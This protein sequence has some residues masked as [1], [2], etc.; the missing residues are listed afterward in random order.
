MSQLGAIRYLVVLGCILLI[1]ACGG[2]GGGG[3]DT[4]SGSEQTESSDSGSSGTSE[5]DNSSEF[6]DSESGDGS[7][8]GNVD[9]GNEAGEN[10]STSDYVAPAVVSLWSD[11]VPFGEGRVIDD[12][13]AFSGTGEPGHI[14]E[15]WLNGVMN[16]STVVD[17]RGEWRIDFTV[18]TLIPDR[19]EVNLV[20]V[21]PAGESVA[22]ASTFTFRYDPTAPA[23]P[24]IS[25]I[26]DDSYVAGD[27]FTTDGTL[28]I[29]GTAEPSM[30]VTLYLNSVAIGTSIA[31]GEGNWSVD[32]SA[33]NLSDGSYMLTADS[34][35]LTL[36]SAISPQFPV[37]IDRVP[38]AAPSVLNISLDSGL[39]ATD[40]ITNDTRLVFD[41]VSEP[42]AQIRLRRDAT[43]LGNTTADASGNWSFDYSVVALSEGA[44]SVQLMATD[45]AGNQ[46]AWSSLFNL[47][48]DTAAPNPIGSIALQPDTGV[49]GDGVTATGAIQ[50]V[51][52]ADA[53]DYVEVFVDGSSVG[54]VL[55]DSSGDWILDLS[56]APLVNGNYS[57]TTQ[58]VDLAGNQSSVSPGFD[59]VINA[60]PPSMPVISG[61]TTDT[62]LASDG[63]TAD[64]TLEVLGTADAGADVYV[65]IDGVGVG[66]TTADMF[67]NWSF[68]HTATVLTDGVHILTAQAE[69]ISGLQS[70]M[71]V[72][73]NL[74]IDTAAPVVPAITSMTTDTGVLG[75]LITGDNTLLFSGTSEADATIEVFIGGS[76]VGTTTAN[77]SGV[78]TFD[79]SGT[80][81]S[82]GAYSITATAQDASGNTSVASSA[83]AIT[84]DTGLPAAPA[85]T[86][87]T[88]DTGVLG[89]LITGDNTL[90]FSGTSEA[91]ATIEIFIGASSVGTTTAN[92]SGVWTF[93]YSGTTLSDGAY[94]I[95][96]TAQDASGNTS[97]ASSAYAITIDTGLPA[98]P[99]ITAMTTD[100]G[101]LGDLI[102]GDNTLLF[103]GTS[104]A[105]ATIEIFIGAS[106]VGTTTANGS[107]VWTFDYSGTTFS[108]GAYSIT[109][110]AQDAS[111]NTSVA[112][113]SFNLTI[114]VVAPAA[115]S[116]DSITLDSGILGDLIT[117]D[118]TLLISGTAEANS[119]VELMVGGI[120]VGTVA[121]NGSGAW[122]FDYTGTVLS[123][124]SYLFSAT[125]TDT[126][127][128]NSATSSGFA[129]TIDSSAPAAPAVTAITTDTGSS[130][131]ITSDNSLV[132]SGAAEANS[133]VTVFV[134]AGSIGTT[135]ASGAGAWSY[136]Y[137]G[138]SLSDGTYSI[139]ASTQ[140]TAGNT[141]ALSSTFSV[142]VDSSTPAAPA[143][144]GITTDSGANDGITNDNTLIISG[145]GEV[146]LVVDL[147]LDG[148]SILTPTVNGSGV[149]TADYTGASLS[150]G[151]YTLTATQ[152]DAADNT[153]AVSSG[154]ALQVDT[155]NPTLSTTSPADGATTVG[156]N[157]NLVLNFDS[158][159]YV[160]S[161][162]I[163][164]KRSSD[165]STFETIP[166]GDARVT[167]SGTSSITV[168][169]A[170][171]FYGGT[172]Y[173]VQID[174][175]AFGDLAANSYAGIAN[176]TDWNF[177]TQATA[178]ASSTP[179]DEATGV[180]LNSTLT[181][182]FNETVYANTGNVVIHKTSDDSVWD[183]IAIS[184]GQVSGSG[185]ASI[186]ITQTDVLEPN[187]GYYLTIDS[188]ALVNG[189]GASF[190]GISA[191][192]DLNFVSVN[193]SVPTVTNVTSSTA[194]G[195][196]GVGSSINVSVTF[197]ES[198]DVTLASPYINV[199]LDGVDRTAGYVSGTGTATLQFT[200][201]VAFGDGAADLD[202]VDVSSLVLNSALIRSVN[203]ANADLTLPAPTT[204]GSLSANKN[205]AITADVID[206]ATMTSSDGFQVQGSTAGEHIGWAVN[207]VGDVNGDGFE[208]FVTG[209]PDNN[210]SAG[211][212]YIVYGQAGSTRSNFNSSTITNGTNGFKIIGQSAVDKLGGAVGG[213]GDINDD[214]YDDIFV[215]APLEDNYASDGGIVYIIFGQ[216]SNSDVN[217][218]SFSSSNG[219]RVT[220]SEASARIGDSFT[221]FSGNGQGIDAGGDFNGDGI[222]DLIVGIRYS[223]ENGAD[224]GKAYLIFG[225]SGA[226]RGDVDLD[227]ID[228]TGPD[229]M[230]IYGASAGWQLGQSA[231]FVGDYDADGYDD[232]VVS[233]IFSGAVASNGGQS[234][235]I[236]GSPGPIFN[237]IDVATLS[238]GSGF[239]ISS[240]EVGSIIG[241]SVDGGDFNG[242]GIS[243]LLV[244]SNG[245]SI[246]G[247]SGNGAAFVIYGDNGGSYGNIDVDTLL[248][249]EGFAI[250]G[251]NDADNMSHSLASA[252]DFNVDGVD[253][254]LLGAYIN[255]EGGANAGAGY[256]VMGKDGA[257]RA[258][259]DLATLNSNDGIKIIGAAA[260]DRL[261]QA[262]GNA[263][264]NG[265]GFND[266]ILGATLG[267]NASADGGETVVIWGRELSQSVNT[268]LAGDSGA[269]NLVGTS[270]NDTIVTAGG[271]DAVAAGAGDDVIQL[272]DTTFYNI[273]G[274]LGTD[275]LQF[276]TTLNNLDLTAIGPEIINGIEVIDLAD[277]GNT[278][279]LS[280]KSML[281]LSRE[282]RTL[283]VKGGSSDAVVSSSG[284][285]WCY[286]GTQNVSGINYDIY[287]DEGA[288]LY[289]QT[290]IDSSAVPSFNSTQTYSF[291][292]TGGGAN[293]SGSVTDFP[294]LIRVSSGIVS[295]LQG[296]KADIRFT[297][298]DQ[299]TWLPYEIEVG[300]SGELYAWVLVPQVDGNSSGDYIV[301][302]YNDVQN[303]TVPDRQNPSKLWKDYGAV[304]HFDEGTSGTA[305]DS[306]A[307]QNHAAQIS[308]SVGDNPDKLIGYGRNFSG[309]EALQAP[310]DISFNSSNQAFTVESWVREPGLTL[311]G[312]KTAR[313]VLSRGTSGTYWE[314]TSNSA[315]LI[316]GTPPRFIV[317]DGGFGQTSLSFDGGG[318]LFTSTQWVH[319][320]AV[321]DPASG[322]RIYSNGGLAGTAA[323]KATENG[324]PFKMGN[325][326]AD[327]QLDEVRYGRFAADANRIK[328]NYENQRSGS[329]FVSPQ[330]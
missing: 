309:N 13:V 317:D 92:G 228:T 45:R 22:S 36:Q 116:V 200:Y 155:A 232:I 7:G 256:L 316:I 146:G 82:D 293:V 123:D 278:L 49:V 131:G 292:T 3:S 78:W 76:S 125:A 283:F 182:N 52:T 26:T 294:V 108:D 80:T 251:E 330:F 137:T 24:I 211:V 83:Y 176:T 295:S 225:E 298:K 216:A 304:W 312:L 285:G 37:V 84:I 210:G 226:T 138:T 48:I 315:T 259:V 287:L 184:S 253:D 60:L 152:S 135:T 107:G 305:Y 10:T 81:L 242:D 260:N 54:Q 233:A 122:S 9:P 230:L 157:D 71:S 103:S 320:V 190:A 269:N 314:M 205:I 166:V 215:A 47:M 319:Q 98:A 66:V 142:T 44:H 74:V 236:F 218:S 56:A 134:D 150:D 160:Q 322:I 268:S 311:L 212:A 68:D 12:T 276:T 167:G 94:S 270:G 144:T 127:A 55:V 247:K 178:I 28:V 261:A 109:A 306:S 35:F 308:G 102:T 186:T 8:T 286:T 31:D 193:V 114:D 93:D 15:F 62:G 91:D 57:V 111:G 168:N 99:A 207:G 119:T 65:Y 120:S 156:F 53:G 140:D 130:D 273:E 222:D 79:Y 282:T 194:D 250:Y 51:G 192:T 238:G 67:G 183:T 126:A 175:S 203:Y 73:F 224:S 214:G 327:V 170:G 148:S 30:T 159:V 72:A 265:D 281:S 100:T 50:L 112:S 124:G 23:S 221:D 63:I 128:N 113:T 115:P 34:T 39:S 18:V 169:P 262:S 198:V 243:D 189:G 70:P 240:T 105:D 277:S 151:S 61:I 2:G 118:N 38:P 185:S 32:Y 59:I 288:I 29:T 121:A 19:Y 43:V 173:Y 329:S 326:S 41:G 303:G 163:V 279:T 101:V 40:Y 4:R 75:D 191:K 208:D 117:S 258:D 21:S 85:I 241:H 284:D 307:F 206:V 231:R 235:L 252:G 321:I 106:S 313:E 275:T 299:L 11:D 14:L 5:E 328:L 197:S 181:L 271:A 158:N 143:I 289:V 274:G 104:E 133:T 33:V 291:D 6:N 136:D 42:F 86:A 296:S 325:S 302:H 213:A 249:S 318:L 267:D 257:S 229:G 25:S 280:Q 161:G 266:L 219:F 223:D 139:T 129:V 90:L 272:A 227:L 263:D 149:W 177:V 154:F 64:S 172:G 297:D 204:A 195:S 171:T 58:V 69:N 300:A 220:I 162:N 179:A 196:Y 237:A 188:G 290:S 16:A 245:K 246:N 264:V 95:T 209:A 1:T 20:T 17:S 202:Y 87:M 77:G 324:Q 97:V 254:V 110:T 323:Y 301:M 88:T 147:M 165:D 145:T 46:S 239:K 234:F 132:F 255:G 174:A 27:G 310:Y 201:S 164:I 187:T 180:A 199:D 217:I 96:A 89:D 153:S 248:S 141:S 244:S